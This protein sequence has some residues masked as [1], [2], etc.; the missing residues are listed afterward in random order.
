[1]LVAN[2]MNI[3]RT[4]LSLNDPKEKV[5]LTFSSI[6]DNVI[7]N[8]KGSEQYENLVKEKGKELVEEREEFL[9]Q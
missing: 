6:D 7:L 9:K 5:K 4:Y 3:G 8:M 1:M 2:S